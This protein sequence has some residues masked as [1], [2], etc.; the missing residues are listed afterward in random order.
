MNGSLTFDDYKKLIK[1][2]EVISVNHNES[3]IQ[4]S[5]MDLT[6]SSECYELKY[7]FLSPK[8]KI[9]NKLKKLSIKKYNLKNGL[10]FK[11]NHTYLVRLNEKLNLASPIIG[12]CNPKSSTG[13]LDIFCRTILDNS[14]EYEKIPLKYK[15]EMFLEVTCKSFNIKFY[16]GDSL[17]K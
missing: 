15:G 8:G 14:N 4:P 9:R 1:N 12:K 3:R 6:L 13:R 16:E 2:K 10:V 17:N 11:K 7:S 5:S